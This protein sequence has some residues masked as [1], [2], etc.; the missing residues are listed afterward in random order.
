MNKEQE[1][2]KLLK[3]AMEV[4]SWCQENVDD[5]WMK[6]HLLLLAVRKDVDHAFAL[7]KQPQT[8]FVITELH[9]NDSNVTGVF[10]TEVLADTEAAKNEG[11]AIYGCAVKEWPVQ[12][13]VSPAKQPECGTCGGTGETKASVIDD[14][15][16]GIVDTDIP[17][18]DCRKP[19]KKPISMA[20]AVDDCD[21]RAAPPVTE[22]TKDCLSI[23]DMPDDGT[24]KDVEYIKGLE[25]LL[26]TACSHIVKAE[27]EKE[28]IQKLYGNTM[29][30]LF[31][32]EQGIKELEAENKRQW[33]NIN[34]IDSL[35]NSMDEFG[36]PHKEE[37]WP[38]L[39]ERVHSIICDLLTEIKELKEK[40]P[41]SEFTKKWRIKHG[42]PM[43]YN[44]RVVNSA[45]DI[46]DKNE[47]EK[48]D[49]KQA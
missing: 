1:A 45:C 8:V 36:E 3:K 23:I 27:G 34:C 6:D 44:E 9:Q 4:F 41:M 48:K 24:E 2:L 37:K 42:E 49:Y 16:G 35:C 10:A 20:V 17:Y 22:F 26:R 46:I 29:K 28:S 21:I 25:S 43:T 47:A 33:E 32:A 38:F 30:S 14:L 39:S 31:S 12:N 19:A 15:S 11:D 40:P 5:K 7:L 13:C 18:P